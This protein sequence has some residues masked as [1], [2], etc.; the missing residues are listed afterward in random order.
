MKKITIIAL[1]L[2]GMN[3]AANAQ[4]ETKSASQSTKLSLSNAIAITYV[5]NGSAQA[6][7]VNMAFNSV[8]DYANGV[9][10]EEQ[11][12]KVQSNKNFN[13][14][15]KTDAQNFTYSGSTSPAPVANIANILKMKV[16]SNQ[17]GGSLSYQ[18]YASIPSGTAT[19][20]NWGSPGGNRTFT[21]KY[22]ATPGFA[23][24]A[25]TYTANVIYT[26]VQ[27]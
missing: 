4:N 13:V 8:S 3:F 25:G 2:L 22:K 16:T 18:D 21:V 7:G 9:Y 19:I 1:A 27:P 20:I 26:A 24:P 6:T 23:L 11:Q 5:G 12:F 14:T 15:I 10:S 17:T